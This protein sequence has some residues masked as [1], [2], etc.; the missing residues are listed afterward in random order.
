MKEKIL[1]YIKKNKFALILTLVYGIF[2]IIL[3]SFH[4]VWR[5]EVRALNY[6]TEANSLWDLFKNLKI[7]NEGHPALWHTLLYIGYHIFH[8]TIILK[9]LN[10]IISVSAIYI[11]LTFSPFTR[12]QKLIFIFGYFPFYQFS[13]INRN[14]AL[15]MLLL[16]SICA[17]Y[18]VRFK[19]ILIISFL[20]FLFANTHVLTNIITFAF[21][22]SLLVEYIYKLN[23]GDEEIRGRHIKISLG[24]IVILLG[25]AISLL[26][27]IPNANAT[28]TA[29]NNIE[30]DGAIKSFYD[31]F[32]KPISSSYTGF[33]FSSSYIF[34]AIII[35]FYYAYLFSF[36]PFIFLNVFIGI[37][38]IEIFSR[39]IIMLP[40]RQQGIVY[41]YL[42]SIFWIDVGSHHDL[43]IYKKYFTGQLINFK[44][45]I[46]QYKFAFFNFILLIQLSLMPL[47]VYQ[48]IKM[49]YSSS[50]RLANDIFKNKDLR[51]GILIGD[52][53][54]Y[55]ESLSYYINNPIYIPREKKFNKTVSWSTENTPF[56]SLSDILN[57][58][59]YLNKTYNKPVIIVLTYRDLGIN[60]PF[61]RLITAHRIFEYDINSLEEFMKQTIFFGSY[62]NAYGVMYDTERFKENY[63]VYIFPK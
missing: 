55:V 23:N 26:Q 62:K 36:R 28:L 31:S 42:V 6:A 43:L 13:V 56:F 8:S 25:I 60:G 61:I 14:Y 46:Q 59:Q 45:C 47:A 10:I 2:I 21:L 48:D 37:F 12:L 53:D 22:L 20:L 9:I 58:A 39:N 50:K 54:E 18:K 38:I 63:D 4:E 5:D 19:K 49:E 29:I 24:F 51:E 44:N 1:E 35:W 30:I 15:A 16:F 40:L 41:I 52:M 3:S 34:L 17:L 57:T 11:F 7:S 33:G 32:L 27:S